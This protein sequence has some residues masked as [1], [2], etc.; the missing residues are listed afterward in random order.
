M[1][2][3]A[4]RAHVCLCRVFYVRM[5][6]RGSR[7]L[8]DFRESAPDP[9]VS[10]T[11]R[12]AWAFL[13]WSCCSSTVYAAMSVLIR[14]WRQAV[15]GRGLSYSGTVVRGCVATVAVRAQDRVQHSTAGLVGVRRK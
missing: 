12:S 2:L 13:Q 1:I 8:A 4:T 6:T 14:R 11:S 10:A 9:T 15:D 3:R 5:R 7:A